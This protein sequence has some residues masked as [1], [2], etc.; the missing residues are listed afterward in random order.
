MGWW[1]RSQTPGERLFFPWLF[2]VIFRLWVLCPQKWEL[3]DKAGGTISIIPDV[4]TTSL[5]SQHWLLCVETFSA[6]SLET[7]SCFFS[8]KK[9]HA[10]SVFLPSAMVTLLRLWVLL[11]N[12]VTLLSVHSLLFVRVK[13]N[14][15]LAILALMQCW[16]NC[17]ELNQPANIFSHFRATSHKQHGDKF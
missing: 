12:V 16:L 6:A 10:R 1:L 9:P 15:A 2:G 3:W 7:N 11:L 4:R 13:V 5:P 14:V 8:Q 17:S